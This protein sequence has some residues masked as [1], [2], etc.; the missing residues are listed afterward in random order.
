MTET[1]LPQPLLAARS[2]SGVCVFSGPPNNTLEPLLKLDDSK[3]CRCLKFSPHGDYLAWANGAK[4]IV[5]KT[6][7]WSNVV[8][9]DLPKVMDIH[10]SPKGTYFSVYE[11]YSRS[12]DAK[13]E[14]KNLIVYR[15]ENGE[16]LEAFEQRKQE[17][18]QPQWTADEM[19][20]S[21]NVKN[22][23]F[24]WK[25]ELL[26]GPPE[27]KLQNQRIVNY[28]LSPSAPQYH[29]LCYV[30]G[31]S[32][33]PSVCKIFQFPNFD[34]P[35]AHKT[36]FQADRVEMFWN[37]K[38]TVALFLTTVDIDKTGSSYYGKQGLHLI[39]IKG[40]QMNVSLAKEGPIHA[41]EW[42]P[43]ANEFC[44]I[45]GA[46]PPKT[47]LFNTKAEPVF[48]IPCSP[49][50][51]IYYNPQGNIVLLGGF[52]NLQGAV[53]LWEAPAKKL[54]NK[55]KAAD[56]TLVS[57]SPDGT[58]FMTATTAPRLRVCNGYKIWHYTGSLVHEKSWNEGEE[59]WEVVW[60]NFPPGTFKKPQ[61]C[62]EQ[63]KGIASQ[64]PEASKQAYRPPGARGKPSSFKL[65]TEIVDVKPG[66][67]VTQK[68]Q[69]QMSKNA[70]KLKKNREAKKAAKA[71]DGFI[72]QSDVQKLNDYA[73]SLKEYTS[74]DP[75]KEKAIKKLRVK[76]IEIEK[77][78]EQQKAGK[79]LE[80]NQLEKMKNEDTLLKQMKSLAM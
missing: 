6:K 48:D 22:D 69:V 26:T 8:S 37:K 43:L 73:D 32:G 13:D 17:N 31:K 39:D 41:V 3:S 24:F 51:S 20:C 74:T 58:Y 11:L 34:N 29:L 71:V 14:I 12:G 40:N 75:E 66:T 60:Q 56:T 38:G 42:S 33:Q 80:K 19:Y 30:P 23:V 78:K 7:D 62:Y 79:Q 1:A 28:S 53:D 76:L 44:V 59:L 21:R 70:I 57:W 49:I 35:L 2:S 54:I 61:V 64:S 9:L 50:N 16:I 36:F 5:V 67:V 52:G 27:K 65:N 63:V 72:S 68:G 55:T 45:Y 10:F 46:M 77:L 15:T 47:T 18:W 4:V 25:S